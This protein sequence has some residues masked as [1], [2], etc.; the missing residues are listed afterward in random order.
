MLTSEVCGNDGGKEEIPELTARRE[1]EEPASMPAL[2]EVRGRGERDIQDF[3][4][5]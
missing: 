4:S 2:E 3:P 5:P 1:E